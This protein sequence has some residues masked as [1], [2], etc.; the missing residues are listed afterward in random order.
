MAPAK[1][2][3][4]A[5]V[6]TAAWK[7]RLCISGAH[8]GVLSVVMCGFYLSMRL[9]SIGREIMK[10]PPNFVAAEPPKNSEALKGI[11]ALI[12]RAAA[13][14]MSARQ[15]RKHNIK[16]AS[17]INAP[18]R[19]QLRSSIFYIVPFYAFYQPCRPNHHLRLTALAAFARVYMTLI[20]ALLICLKLIVKSQCLNVSN[21]LK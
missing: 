12:M 16:R 20:K 1:S 18:L 21:N 13:A 6:V 15:L 2:N 8:H 19:N 3:A 5:N 9:S 7:W 17:V 14:E 10:W 4:S 11:F